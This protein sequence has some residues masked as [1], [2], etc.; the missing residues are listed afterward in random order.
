MQQLLT[1]ISQ[2]C[3]LIPFI[4]VVLA[5]I[6]NFR[7]GQ[8]MIRTREGEKGMANQPSRNIFSKMEEAP[9]KPLT[10]VSGE[11]AVKEGKALLLSAYIAWGI[12]AVYGLVI[13]AVLLLN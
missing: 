13:A 2:G 12:A 6:N 1:A 7:R 9:Q 4:V 8:A 10:K 11:Q 5:G 3:W